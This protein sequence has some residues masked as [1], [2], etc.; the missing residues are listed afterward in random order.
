MRDEPRSIGSPESGSSGSAGPRITPKCL[1][2]IARARS[3]SLARRRRHERLK[4]PARRALHEA[5][6]RAFALGAYGTARKFYS[7]TVEAWPENELPNPELLIRYS[8][9]LNSVDIGSAPEFLLQAVEIALASGDSG[10]AAEAETLMWRCTGSRGA[11]T[12]RSRPES[13]EGLVENEQSS[14]AKAYVLANVSRFRMLAGDREHAIRVGRQAL[15]MAKNSASTSSRRMRWTTSVSAVSA[16]ATRAVSRT[17]SEASRSPTRSIGRERPRNGNLGSALL[18]LGEV[19]RSFEM[20]A[21]TRGRAERFGLDDWLLWLRGMMTWAPYYSGDWDEAFHRLDELIH[22]FMQ[23][24][25]W[26][27][28]ACR[29]L[30]ARMRLA[31]GDAPGAREDADRALELAR[32]AKDPQVL[33]PALT[34]SARLFVPSDAQT[35]EA[36]IDELLSE[37]EARRWPG[38]SSDSDWTTDAAIV[39]PQVGREAQYLEGAKQTDQPSPWHRATVAYVSGDL[40]AAA[41]IYGE[42]GAG[43]HEAYA[44]LRAAEDLVRE[45]RRAEADAELKRSLSFW[46]L[47]ARP[48]TSERAKR[49]RR[50]RLMAVCPQCG[51]ENRAGARFCDGAARRSPS[52]RGLARGAQGRDGLFADLVGFTS[53]A[54]RWTRRTCA[55]YSSRITRDIAASSSAEAAPSRS[56]SATR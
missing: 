17:S 13:G 33:W 12:T 46:R 4:E 8:R 21:E 49:S 55:P 30:R 37:W 53:R 3:S 45:G 27:E 24:P 16:S 44:R 38:G 32:A 7:Q 42:I 26:M 29:V 35:A 23:H 19:D 54:S 39:L 9:V 6:D 36:L 5:G 48:R 2:T 56:S 43:P 50:E 11:A 25:F 14:Y 47:P 41:E 51:A 15:A 1:R 28:S 22:E 34:L 40:L 20:L 31:R 52:A 18:D 10:Q